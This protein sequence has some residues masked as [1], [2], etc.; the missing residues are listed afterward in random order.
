V[1]VLYSQVIAIKL[2]NLGLRKHHLH[3]S[4]MPSMPPASPTKLWRNLTPLHVLVYGVT[5][6]QVT[7]PR[8]T[9]YSGPF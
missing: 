1:A 2:P 9:R 7:R 8:F 3:R 5:G 4:T 6:W